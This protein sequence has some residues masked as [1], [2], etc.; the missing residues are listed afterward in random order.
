M[1]NQH[2][3]SFCGGDYSLLRDLMT[4]TPFT[5]N[6]YSN[7]DVM[8]DECYYRLLDLLQKSV[9]IRTKHRQSLPPLI[10]PSTSILMKRKETASKKLNRGIRPLSD[11]ILKVQKLLQELEEAVT[12]DRREYEISL[13]DSRN[14]NTVF[15]FINFVKTD[16]S[17]LPTL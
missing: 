5:P 14:L 3:K 16:R 8:V 7:L 6:C 12:N 15:K 4:E 2:S 1:K 13:S 10:S 11:L 9:P 17:A